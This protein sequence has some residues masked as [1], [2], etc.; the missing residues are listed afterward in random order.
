M[1]I[2]FILSGFVIAM[3]EDSRQEPYRTF[4][5]RRFFRLAPVYYLILA[6]GIVDAIRT[7]EYAPTTFWAHVASHVTMLHGLFP[8]EVLFQ[9]PHALDYVSWSIS[10]EWQFYLVAPF[11]LRAIRHSPTR[12]LAV[13]AGFGVVTYVANHGKLTFE[14]GATVFHRAGLF[15]IGIGSYY[16]FKYVMTNREDA[17]KLV[18]YMLPLG[19]AVA[20]V[21][22][23]P[24][25]WPGPIWIILF[26]ERRNVPRR[27]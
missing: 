1:P 13:L 16:F 20:W 8:D 6:M 15:A 7:H 3:M 24:F 14:G 27:G 18:A 23:G 22:G 19:L 17:G 4:I 21:C 5:I 12:A 26:F 2:F 25:V 9:S 11:V 10:V